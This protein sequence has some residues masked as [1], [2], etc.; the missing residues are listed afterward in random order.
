M[1]VTLNQNQI[2]GI[3]ISAGD[4]SGNVI[5]TEYMESSATRPNITYVSNFG[6]NSLFIL[7]DGVVYSTSGTQGHSNNTTGRGTGGTTQ[8]YG[9]DGLK[10]V[11]IPTS[12]PIVQVGGGYYAYAFA[13]DSAGQL[14]TWGVNSVG[15]CGVSTVTQI[16]YPVLAATG[17]VKVYDDPSNGNYDQT[18]TR[19]FILKTDGYVYGT[20]YNGLGALGINSTTNVSVFTKILQTGGIS[21]PA[22]S[23]R[24]LWNLGTLYGMTV[25]QTTDGHIWVAGYNGYGQLGIGSTTNATLFTDTSGA[26]NGGDYTQVLQ[27]VGGG[28]GYYDTAAN[29]SCTCVMWMANPSGVHLIKTCGCSTWGSLGNGG[30]TQVNSTP[31]T[32]NVGTGTIAD[33]ATTGGGPL[34]IH[35]LKSDGTLY[36]WGHNG[37]GEV[38]IG[39]TAATPSPTIVN[40]GVNRLFMHGFT[41]HTYSYRVTMFMEKTDGTIWCT[42]WNGNGELGVGDITQRNG[43]TLALINAYIPMVAGYIKFCTSYQATSGATVTLVVTGNNTI[44]AWGYNGTSAVTWQSATNALYPMEFALPRGERTY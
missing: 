37:L 32:V 1:A 4:V 9:L 25:I 38:G 6:H 5:T 28:F 26:W 13:L 18:S 24:S 11:P 42:G 41:N 36:G 34:T 23:I 3:V 40:T 12:Y 20:G 30:V 15:T 16:P 27:K 44:Y 2:S 8:S 14:F 35:V 29:S 7:A 17:V 21:F 33:I 10:Q 31:Y 22:N 43:W 39:T 19:L